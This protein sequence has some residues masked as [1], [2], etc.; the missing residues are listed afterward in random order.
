MGKARLPK[1]WRGTKAWSTEAKPKCMHRSWGFLL[2]SWQQ[3]EKEREKGERISTQ[4]SQRQDPRSNKLL[5]TS[6][7][8]YKYTLYTK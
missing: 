1:D 5:Y 8:Y 2:S 6:V 7:P 3:Y 4:P